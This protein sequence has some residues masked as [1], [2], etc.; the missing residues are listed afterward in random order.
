MGVGSDEISI[1]SLQ[2][3]H[4]ALPN[5]VFIDTNPAPNLFD[6]IKPNLFL[7]V[8][9]ALNQLLQA[10]YKKIGFIGGLGQSLNISKKKIFV[11]L[12]LENMLML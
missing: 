7:T 8:K 12:L 11:K 9:D 4:K 5:G 3:L 2:K 6:S 10:G 1:A